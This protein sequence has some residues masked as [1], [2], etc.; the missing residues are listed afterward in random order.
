MCTE[1]LAKWCPI[2]K[3]PF[4]Y[5]LVRTRW[6]KMKRAMSTISNQTRLFWCLF[7]WGGL[8]FVRE[9]FKTKRRLVITS[10]S[11][12][13]LFQDLSTEKPWAKLCL[14]MS[15]WNWTTFSGGC[16]W[17]HR[18]RFLSSAS[19]GLFSQDDGGSPGKSRWSNIQFTRSYL[20]RTNM[21]VVFTMDSK[22]LYHRRVCHPCITGLKTFPAAAV[23]NK[24]LKPE[25]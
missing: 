7:M 1:L 9:D 12:L 17:H 25:G 8:I 15:E 16:V 23:C 5:L 22:G 13:T 18:G 21:K 19:Q 24:G 6:N 10:R 20:I 4:V 3:P 14:M 11:E 2:F